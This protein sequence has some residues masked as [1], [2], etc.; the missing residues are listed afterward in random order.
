MKFNFSGL[1]ILQ[2]LLKARNL[3]LILSIITLISLGFLTEFL[4]LYLYQTITQSERIILLKSEVA[5][6]SININEVNSV[7]D[8]INKKSTPENINWSEIKNPFAQLTTAQPITPI[9]P[10]PAKTN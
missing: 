9:E 7:L 8:F 3:Y 1:K 2:P 5:P 4:Y 10:A 6:D